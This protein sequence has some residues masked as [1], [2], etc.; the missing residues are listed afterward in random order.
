MEIE[1][2]T[3]YR[4]EGSEFPTLEKAKDYI[5][6]EVNQVLHAAMLKKGFSASEAF[7][8]T[9]IVLANKVRLAALLTCEIPDEY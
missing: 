7:K 5:D 8:I 3:R 6:G 9:E 4:V 2:V 1:R